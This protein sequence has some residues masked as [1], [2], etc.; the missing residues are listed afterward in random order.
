VEVWGEFI[1]QQAASNG[2]IQRPGV[3][4]TGCTKISFLITFTDIIT[5]KN[6]FFDNS[7]EIQY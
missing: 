3:C 1:L 4:E 2:T 6:E 5:V 7:F